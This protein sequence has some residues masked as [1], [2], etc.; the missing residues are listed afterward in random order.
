M[1]DVPTPNQL[2]NIF[3]DTNNIN[4]VIKDIT[5]IGTEEHHIS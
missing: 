2:L 4:Q 5:I 1:R 3:Q